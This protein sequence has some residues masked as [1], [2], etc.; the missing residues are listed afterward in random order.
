MRT[1]VTYP[2]NTGFYS[3][4]GQDLKENLVHLTGVVQFGVFA[5]LA[6]LGK[7]SSAGAMDSFRSPLPILPGY[8][9]R[10]FRYASLRTDAGVPGC[11]GAGPEVG[12]GI[13]TFSELS[14]LFPIGLSISQRE[15]P[16]M[17]GV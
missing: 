8:V 17:P 10:L 15:N 11:G 7:V 4:W 9:D 14:L 6:L 16:S 12:I 5:V 3:G 2:R 13:E 1:Q